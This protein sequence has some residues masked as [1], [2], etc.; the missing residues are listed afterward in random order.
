MVIAHFSGAFFFYSYRL[1]SSVLSVV[2]E[3]ERGRTTWP[4]QK[5][6]GPG[7]DVASTPRHDRWEC[8]KNRVSQPYLA[9]CSQYCSAPAMTGREGEAGGFVIF[10]PFCL[11][12]SLTALSSSDTIES[13]GQSVSAAQ[14]ELVMRGPTYVCSSAGTDRQHSRVRASCSAA[15][16]DTKQ[17][18]NEWV[19]AWETGIL[20]SFPGVQRKQG[21]GRGILSRK[22]SSKP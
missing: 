20:W 3:Q 2:A 18:R 22:E 12:L 14:R 1:R 13:V 7:H 11:S 19:G 17:R 5:G 15:E 21:T 10:S 4:D 9:T 6:A 8:S 16:Y